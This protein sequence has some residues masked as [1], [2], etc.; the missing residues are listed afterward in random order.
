LR[1]KQKF[2]IYRNPGNGQ[3]KYERY[4]VPLMKGMSVLE[5]LFYI[6]DHY[7]STLA[8]RYACRGA[9]CG[10]CG[11]TIDKVPSLA[12]RVQVSNIKVTKK[13]V[14]L[15]E[16]KFG[17]ISDW[18]RENEILIEPMPNMEIIKDLIVNMEPFWKFYRE[19]EPYLDRE[20]KD[21]SPESQQF[22]SEMKKIERLVYCI[23]CGLC[24]ACPVNKENPTYLGPAQLAK[25]D[26]FINDSRIKTKQQKRILSRV[27]KEDAV[28]ACQKYFVCNMVCP[29]DVMPGTAIKNIRDNWTNRKD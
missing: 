20:W 29:K 13:P 18:D 10:S 12:C 23:L 15:P 27:L 25:A 8:F 11:M 16:F 28:P 24:W 21:S 6:Q 26:R 19:V 5:A 14:N 4:E 7:D 3:I 22:P 1:D 2:L 9:I 17:K